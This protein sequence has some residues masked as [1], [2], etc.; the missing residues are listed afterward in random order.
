MST[1]KLANTTIPEKQRAWVVVKRGKPKNALVF[2]QKA[3]VPSDLGPGEVL[4]RVQAAAL[5]PV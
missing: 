3:P 4:L 2:D 5:N 1:A